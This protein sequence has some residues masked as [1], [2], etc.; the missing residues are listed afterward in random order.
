M[1]FKW[2]DNPTLDL[3][4]LEEFPGMVGWEEDTGYIHVHAAFMRGA[5][6]WIDRYLVDMLDGEEGEFMPD[7]DEMHFGFYKPGDSD[8]IVPCD[9]NDEQALPIWTYGG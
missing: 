1:S 6:R 5:Q 2:L 3:V 9:A 7:D 8:A 4:H